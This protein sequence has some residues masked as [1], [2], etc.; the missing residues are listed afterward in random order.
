MQSVPILLPLSEKTF[1]EY[2]ALPGTKV[3]LH[4]VAGENGEYCMEQMTEIYDGYFCKSFDLFF[5]ET[6]QYYITEENG[7]SQVLTKSATVEKSDSFN[8]STESRY[9]LLNQIIMSANL[10]E[11]ESL[12][13]MIFDYAKQSFVADKLFGIE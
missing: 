13:E 12:K 6:L 3:I 1:V 7:D 11:K 8:L 9:T 4:Y 10:D 2:R 5:G